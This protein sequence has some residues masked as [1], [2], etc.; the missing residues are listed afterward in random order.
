MKINSP[1]VVKMKEFFE[2]N[3]MIYMVMEFCD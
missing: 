2:D 1:H 3:T